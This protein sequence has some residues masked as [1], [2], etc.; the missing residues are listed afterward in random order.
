MKIA[1]GSINQRKISSTKKIFK[2][3]LCNINS[4]IVSF[5]VKSNVPETPWNKQIK[6]GARNRAK[7]IY[8][9]FQDCD[10]AI[11]IESG[12]VD[13][14]EE[15]YEESWACII[16]KE[17]KE[18]FGYSSGLKIPNFILSK[19]NTNN[20]EHWEIMDMLDHQEGRGNND[21]TWGTYSAKVIVRDISLQES[22]R[23]AL[24]Q[25][26]APK[27]SYYHKR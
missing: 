26:H 20:K 2:E 5:P 10:Y 13:R 25:I 4:K 9:Q 11:G 18:Y 15:I 16:T 23:N 24:I 12:L 3:I 14:Y 6:T 19:M 22:L 21:D 8:T 17:K 27:E 7:N 1:I